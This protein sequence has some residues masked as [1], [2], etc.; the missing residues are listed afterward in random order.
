[1]KNKA[2]TFHAVDFMRT[3]RQK[4]SKLYLKDKDKYFAELE[5]A[6]KEFV[7]TRKKK[8]AHAA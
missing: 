1:M 4:L 5:K 3:T 6:T 2:K 8:I 7:R